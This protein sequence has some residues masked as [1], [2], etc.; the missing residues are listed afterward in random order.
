MKLCILIPAY[1][2]A[3]VLRE[4]IQRISLPGV[5]DEIIVVDDASQDETWTVA[6][7]LP[8]VFVFKNP[9]NLGY[10]GTSQRLY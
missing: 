2:C 5:E 1:N 8:R 3:H 4:L 10:G 9:A 6:S 7:R